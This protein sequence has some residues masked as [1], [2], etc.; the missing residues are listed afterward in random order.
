MPGIVNF[1]LLGTEYFV[2]LQIFS[3]F[4]LRCS[5]LETLIHAGLSFMYQNS[6]LSRVHFPHYQGKTLLSYSKKYPVSYEVSSLATGTKHCAK[7]YVMSGDCP[8]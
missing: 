8:L 3:R 2:L 5:Y 1:I 7:L 6:T 4:F